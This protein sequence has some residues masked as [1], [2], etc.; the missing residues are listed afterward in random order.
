MSY[1]HGPLLPKNPA[2][3][4]ELICLALERKYGAGIELAAL[5]D[6]LEMRAHDTMAARLK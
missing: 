3:A 4:D 6:S 5:D 2:V 1:S